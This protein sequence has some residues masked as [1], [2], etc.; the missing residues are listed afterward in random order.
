[1]SGADGQGG[2]VGGAGAARL[3]L[4]EKPGF[5][6]DPMIMISSQFRELCY[7]AD[8]PMNQVFDVVSH[9][10]EC[11][12]CYKHGKEGVCRQTMRIAPPPHQI[13]APLIYY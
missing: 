10:C 1:M 6:T 13:H 5:N 12:P 3:G 7:K 9:R 2:H 8:D 11:D 4:I